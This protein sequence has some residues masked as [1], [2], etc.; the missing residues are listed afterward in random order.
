MIVLRCVVGTFSELLQF[1]WSRR[2]WWL[3]PLVVVLLL[4]AVVAI[5]GSTVGV[6]PFIYTLF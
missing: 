1:F 2:L 3:I 6:G 5:L 4:F